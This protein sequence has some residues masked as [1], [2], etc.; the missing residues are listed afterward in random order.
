MVKEVLGLVALLSLA[1]VGCSD[2]VRERSEPTGKAAAPLA[3]DDCLANQDF[4][5]AGSWHGGFIDQLR[6][7]KEIRIGVKFDLPRIGYLNPATNEVEGFDVD[8]GKIVASRLGHGVK[9]TVLQTKSADRI[10]FLQQDEVDLVAATMTITADRKLLIDFSNVYFIA[11]QRVLVPMNST[12]T[13]VADLYA[14]AA[15][16]CSVTGSTAAANIQAAAPNAQLVLQ[17]TSL[18][19]FQQLQQGNVASMS[20]DD[21]A[22]IGLMTLDPG[23][24]KLVGEALSV[25]PFGMG[26]KKGREEFVAFVN[27]TLTRVKN[28]GTWVCLYNKWLKPLTNE[29]ATPPLDTVP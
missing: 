26:I 15:T 10:P 18:A 1:A 5:D 12:I 7:R 9:A 13:S 20:T 2:G 25:E 21:V 17:P 8:L 11:H 23:R 4:D 24:F 28:N 19:C 22:L 6:D 29:D 27:D 14:Q 16:V 3:G